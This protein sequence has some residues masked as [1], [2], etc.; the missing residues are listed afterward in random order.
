MLLS[1]LIFSFNICQLSDFT[2]MYHILEALRKIKEINKDI[3]AKLPK[4]R[5]KPGPCLPSLSFSVSRG[6]KQGQH[7]SLG[8]TSWAVPP[9]V[10][11]G[12]IFTAH[13][14]AGFRHQASVSDPLLICVPSAGGSL[15]FGRIH[16]KII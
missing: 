11:E 10:L 16:S 12:L 2:Q 4:G 7:Q 1:E 8:P 14:K 3:L 15:Q 9:L 6:N 13:R 5:Q